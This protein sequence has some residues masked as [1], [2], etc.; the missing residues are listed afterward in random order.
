MCNNTASGLCEYTLADNTSAVV[1]QGQIGLHDSIPTPLDCHYTSTDSN[2]KYVYLG[3]VVNVTLQQDV[4]VHTCDNAASDD[5]VLNVHAHNCNAGGGATTYFEDDDCGYHAHLPIPIDV[6]H[7]QLFVCM[8]LY[9]NGFDNTLYNVYVTASASTTFPTPV[10]TPSAPTPAPTAV[11]TPVPTAVP[12]P[13]PTAVLPPMTATVCNA[14]QGLG[15]LAPNTN[16]SICTL[17][18]AHTNMTVMHTSTGSVVL[19]ATQIAMGRNSRLRCTRT[20]TPHC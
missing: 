3:F 6:T 20:T 19:N 7:C 9:A 4:Y 1:V 18:V 5:T 16:H 13:V 12:T 10:P 11:P 15:A 8:Q 2:L 14:L 17:F